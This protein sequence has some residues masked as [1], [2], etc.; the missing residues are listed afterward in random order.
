MRAAFIAAVVLLTV[1][2]I[3]CCGALATAGVLLSGIAWPIKRASD[4]CFAVADVF[5]PGD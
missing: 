3:I 2:S 4:L 1:I 5:L